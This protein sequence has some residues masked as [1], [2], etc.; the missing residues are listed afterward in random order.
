MNQLCER[1]DIFCS[2]TTGTLST[3]PSDLPLY[4]GGIP[5]R[6]GGVSIC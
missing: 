5:E 6:G 3:A 2:D 4:G 1:I